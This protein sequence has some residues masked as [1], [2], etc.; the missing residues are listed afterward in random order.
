[1]SRARIRV[2]FLLFYFEAWDSLAEVY[3]IMR[4]DERFEPIVVTIPRKLTGYEDFADEDKVSAYLD[5][6]QIA[7]L[8]FDLTDSMDGLSRLRELAPDYLFLNYPWQR[9]YQPGYQIENLVEFTKVCYVPYYSMPLVNEPGETGIAP[10]L[11]QQRSHQLASMVFTQDSTVREAYA[12]T[13]RGNSHVYLTGSPK[14][15]ALLRDAKAGAQTWPIAAKKVQHGQPVPQRN[16]RIIWAPHHSYGPN[17]LNFGMFAQMYQGMLKFAQQHP[18]VDIVLRPHPFLFGTLQDRGVIS[19]TELDD[20]LEDW[21]DLSNTSIDTDGG[22]AA[23]FRATDL[24]VTDGISFIGEFPL[25]TGKPTVFLEN[26]GH[27]EFSPLGEIAA[28]ANIRLTSFEAFEALFDEIHTQG[29]PDYSEPIAK[30]RAA[31]SPFP[32]Q[33]AARIVDAV[34]NDFVAQTPLVNKS[35]VTE[36]AWEFRPGAEPQID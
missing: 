32:G 11:Y 2:V 4:K 25:I 34:A 15:D 16:Y 31:A 26:P 19:A 6:R 1:M 10:H 17:W 35:L 20:W 21:Q 23:L 3:E 8:R 5:A 36:V 29:L 18:H 30:L 12:Q 28:A 7:H 14:I 22:Y 9:N 13:E 24:M 33:A 27:W